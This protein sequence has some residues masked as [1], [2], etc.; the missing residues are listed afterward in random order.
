MDSPNN[1]LPALVIAGPIDSDYAQEMIRLAD[2]LLPGSVFSPH[3]SS[4]APNTYSPLPMNRPAIH[5]TGILQGDAKWG[6][7]DCCEALIL[8]SHQENFGIAVAEALSCGR[9]VLISDK[10]NIF[11]EVEAARAGL[12]T[13]NDL[14]GV[15]S[16]LQRWVHLED[17]DCHEMARNAERL[18]HEQFHN[19]TTALHLLK[20]LKQVA[21]ELSF[22]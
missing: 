2:E 3:S 5:F 15:T 9:P 19:K 6:A 13:S 17:L 16:L 21:P 18:F 20:V 10:V 7:L 12:V 11:R 22:S 4:E 8:P 1:A 14:E